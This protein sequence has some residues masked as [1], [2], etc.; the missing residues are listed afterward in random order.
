MRHFHIEYSI[1]H[2]D[3]L[4]QKNCHISTDGI[5]LEPVAAEWQE[6]LKQ[7]AHGI[8]M[9]KM[10]PLCDI[11]NACTYDLRVVIPGSVEKIK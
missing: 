8:S 6:N 11:A 10:Y 1:F 5:V 7:N 4:K 9:F 2:L 3:S